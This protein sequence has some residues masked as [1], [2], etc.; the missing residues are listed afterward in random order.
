MPSEP[1]G[2]AWQSHGEAQEQMTNGAR[3]VCVNMRATSLG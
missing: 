2:K 1:F 3:L